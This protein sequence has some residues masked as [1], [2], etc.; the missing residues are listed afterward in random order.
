MSLSFKALSE[1]LHSVSADLSAQ[2]EALERTTSEAII[3]VRGLAHGLMPVPAGRGGLGA[4]LEQLAAGVSSTH[5]M[6][7][8][9][10][11][12]DPVDIENDIIATNLYRIAQEAVNNAVRHSRATVVKIRLDDEHGKVTLSVRDNGIGFPS[13]CRTETRAVQV[14]G[15]GLRIMAYRASVINYT[16]TVDS[17]FGDGTTIRVQEC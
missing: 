10:D 7:C 2:A 17:T 15:S 9:F 11:F 13:D 8:V 16:L 14:A 1:T 12:N 3:S 6:R 5:K 4:A